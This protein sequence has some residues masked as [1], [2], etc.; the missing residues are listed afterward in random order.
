MGSESFGTLNLY[1]YCSDNQHKHRFRRRER[2][3]LGVVLSERTRENISLGTGIVADLWETK[4]ESV[5]L[6][7][8]ISVNCLESVEDVSA[9]FSTAD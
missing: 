6:N 8:E 2:I 1:C 3:Y 9:D 4:A 5:A 7:F